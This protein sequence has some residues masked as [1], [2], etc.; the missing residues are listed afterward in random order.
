[1]RLELL[2]QRPHG[3]VERV[4][5]AV[6][7]VGVRERVDHGHVAEAGAHA[8]AVAAVVAKRA[9]AHQRGRLDVRVVEA[10]AGRVLDE[11]RAEARRIL[12]DDNR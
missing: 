1:M 5:D 9:G 6:A 3:V 8:H 7:E 11:Q 12:I 10:V 4:L 2:L